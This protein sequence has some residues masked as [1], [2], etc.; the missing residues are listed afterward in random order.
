VREPR[1]PKMKVP[2]V[3]AN[4]RA[5]K[6][7]PKPIPRNHSPQPVTI[8]AET[9]RATAEPKPVEEP[10]RPTAALQPAEATEP[11]AQPEKPMATHP[12][13][14]LP[15]AAPVQKDLP[16]TTES[17]REPDRQQLPPPSPML[18][19]ALRLVREGLQAMQQL[20]QQTA[21]AHQRFLAGQEQ[22]H[23]VFQQVLES[24]QRVLSQA[25][26]SS[27]SDDATVRAAPPT[28]PRF[29][30]SANQ[31]SLPQPS[32]PAAP[33]SLPDEAPAAAD[34]SRR[35]AGCTAIAARSTWCKSS[36]AVVVGKCAGRATA[37]ATS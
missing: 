5:S 22:A 9:E 29:A 17:H 33:K 36:P 15:P 13:A 10:P 25:A 30:P 2:L 35:N 14:K 28:P 1:K 21:E 31:V 7:T 32:Q 23:R 34:D 19:D 26:G 37:C 24:Q 20:Q 11:S 12:A 6:P 4:Y 18:A 16:V 27:A 8:A 3:G